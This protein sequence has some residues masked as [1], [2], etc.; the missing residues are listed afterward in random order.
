[1]AKGQTLMSGR[2]LFIICLGA[3]IGAIACATV[4]KLLH[5]ERPGSLAM[6]MAGGIVG[7]FSGRAL[8]RI[9]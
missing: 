4:A 7:A 1:M 5:I 2:R 8:T 6:G 9:G 3:V